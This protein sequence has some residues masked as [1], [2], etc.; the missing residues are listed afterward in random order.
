[1]LQ[2]QLKYQSSQNFLTVVEMCTRNV[3]A[4]GIDIVAGFEFMHKT[5]VRI[6]RTLFSVRCVPHIDS[7]S[8]VVC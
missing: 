7:T 2:V 8:P 4:T 1:M 3:E 5:I 6:F